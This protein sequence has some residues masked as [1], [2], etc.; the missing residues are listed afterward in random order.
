MQTD[1]SA[2]MLDVVDEGVH[3]RVNRQELIIHKELSHCW[4]AI[5]WLNYKL[6]SSDIYVSTTVTFT[7]NA[8][9]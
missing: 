8:A 2:L 9:F 1:N 7:R 6:N 4:K 5:L 3:K